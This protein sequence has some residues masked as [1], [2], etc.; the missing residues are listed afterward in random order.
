MKRWTISK[1]MTIHNCVALVF[2][3]GVLVC[4]G[5]ERGDPSGQSAAFVHPHERRAWWSRPLAIANADAKVFREQLPWGPVD[6]VFE[7]AAWRNGMWW[8]INY[9]PPAGEEG[10]CL[11]LVDANSGWARLPPA[12]YHP[13]VMASAGSPASNQRAVPVGAPE[14]P[15]GSWLLQIDADAFRDDLPALAHAINDMARG[16]GLPALAIV[17]QAPTPHVVY[18]WQGEYGMAYDPA[19]QHWL[20]QAQP[21]WRTVWID[22][23]P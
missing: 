21:S 9:H 10:P 2:A 15:R 13:R 7:P 20:A 5:C 4:T 11:V 14:A 6:R 16:Q 23:G 18:G 3:V 17:R 8:Q 19:L 22:L 1:I 12:D